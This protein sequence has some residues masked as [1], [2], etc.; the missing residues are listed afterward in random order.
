M[1]ILIVG[2]KLVILLSTLAIEEV[3]NSS[4]TM[5]FYTLYRLLTFEN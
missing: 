4:T 1:E 3:S 2:T 5:N